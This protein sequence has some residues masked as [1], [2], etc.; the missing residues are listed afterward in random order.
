MSHVS[1]DQENFETLF[2]LLSKEMKQEVEESSIYY[3]TF[4][5]SSK[6]RAKLTRIHTV[7]IKWASALRVDP[8]RLERL[9]LL[10]LLLMAL[11]AVRTQRRT[12]CLVQCRFPGGIRV[13]RPKTNALHQLLRFRSSKMKLLLIQTF[14]RRN[15]R[16]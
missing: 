10:P 16:A 11:Q 6:A 4:K 12:D 8:E 1:L 9:L 14:T 5:A 7:P 2:F 15:G 13:V 3:S